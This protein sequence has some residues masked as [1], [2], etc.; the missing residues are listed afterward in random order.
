MAKSGLPKI[1]R[2]SVDFKL[3]AV[4]MSGQLGVLTKDVAQSTPA[5]GKDTFPF[6]GFPCVISHVF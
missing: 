5:A 3:R 4:Q 1:H 6:E 2:Y